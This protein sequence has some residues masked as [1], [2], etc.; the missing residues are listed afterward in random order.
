MAQLEKRIS[1]DEFSGNVESFFES[2]VHEQTTVVV[3]NEK[4]ERIR[5]QPEHE[6][7]C[8]ASAGPDRPP[9]A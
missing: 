7:D 3:E 2:V 8:P 5:G 6:R 4:G 9:G 1:I